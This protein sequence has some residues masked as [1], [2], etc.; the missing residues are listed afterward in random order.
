MVGWVGLGGWFEGDIR[1]QVRQGFEWHDVDGL[2]VSP[3][4][5]GDNTTEPFTA[6]TLAFDSNWGDGVRI[7]GTPGGSGHFTSISELEVYY[8][9]D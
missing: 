9:L 4:Y 1:V 7:I 8:V 5:P 6:Y 2:S 3:D